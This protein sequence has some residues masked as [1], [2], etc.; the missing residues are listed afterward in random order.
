MM[1][2]RTFVEMTEN[3]RHADGRFV[4]ITLDSPACMVELTYFHRTMEYSLDM[5]LRTNGRI[6]RI[7]LC[8]F[9]RAE[10]EGPNKV[11][12]ISRHGHRCYM[13][14]FDPECLELKEWRAY[15]RA[16]EGC[17]TIVE[18]GKTMARG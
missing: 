15:P 7:L 8:D 14:V 17:S 4:N 12:L 11:R 18:Q 9:I 1:D 5:Y 16:S 6:D 13:P 10:A 3:M 2:P